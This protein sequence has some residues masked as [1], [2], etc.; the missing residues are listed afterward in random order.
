MRP[1][2]DLYLLFVLFDDVKTLNVE[3]VW[4]IPSIDFQRLTAAQKES[5]KVIVFQTS[6]SGTK[7]M[8]FKYRCERK[9]L[10]DRI[11]AAIERVH[12]AARRRK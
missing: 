12:G 11:V 7:N 4:L 1:R 5:R 6:L 3:N 9:E 8:W 10:A 2:T